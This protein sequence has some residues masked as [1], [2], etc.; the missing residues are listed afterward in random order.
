MYFNIAQYDTIEKVYL[1][2]MYQL[3]TLEIDKV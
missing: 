3:Y 2:K 1:V